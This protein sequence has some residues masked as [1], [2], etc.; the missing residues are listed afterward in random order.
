MGIA[1]KPIRKLLEFSNEFRISVLKNCP[2]TA[3]QIS[4][5]SEIESNFQG[6]R[7]QQKGHHFH[8]KLQ[9]SQLLTKFFKFSNNGR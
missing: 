4:T 2:S 6:H 1:I 3:K 5:G 9:I 8:M 7:I